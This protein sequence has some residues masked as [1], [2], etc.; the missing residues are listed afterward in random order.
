MG[1][2]YKALCLAYVQE[3]FDA[4]KEEK[5]AYL[6]K[7]R[8]N[9][10]SG[11]RELCL[12][13]AGVVGKGFYHFF[14]KNEIP[15]S[16]FC[17]N[18]PAKWGKEV[19]GN[20]QCISPQEL[21]SRKEHTCV[22]ISLGA[23]EEVECQ[24]RTMGCPHVLSMP[25]DYLA[26]NADELWTIDREY[27]CGGLAQTFDLLEDELSR[28]T[29]YMQVRNLLRPGRELNASSYREALVDGSDYF[30]TD[31]FQFSEGERIVDCG[32]YQGDT[33]QEFLSGPGGNGFGSYDCFELSADMFRVLR[34]YVNTLDEE[35]QRK[36]G[37]HNLGVSD[38]KG[39]VQ[40]FS[41]DAGT[42]IDNP[43]MTGANVERA[44]VVGLDEY[45]ETRDVSFLKM[46]IEGSEVLALHGAER[47]IR[48]SRPK[49]AICVYH[50]LSHLW[51]V[52]LLLKRYVPEYKLY[53]RHTTLIQSDTI[54]YAK[55]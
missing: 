17:D 5:R 47:I 9:V 29:L 34:D 43:W 7:L 21:E 18:D 28:H 19:M 3:R 16:C 27:F 4:T 44:S 2:D 31:I 14:R 25:A 50:R 42:C 36:I 20:V 11:K 48:K 26:Y 23:V 8:E 41:L 22:A 45:L 49:C 24:L 51:E 6:S 46:D 38:R 54:C 12:F 52:P 39:S 55:L 53:L 13:G 37:L 32:A 30:R 40:Y 15:I 35:T 10:L 1:T 33:L